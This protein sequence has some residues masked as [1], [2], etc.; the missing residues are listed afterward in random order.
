MP[1][2][3]FSTGFVPKPLTIEREE[4]NEA[5]RQAYGP[6][7]DT[8]DGSALGQFVGI[9]AER[10]ALLWELAEAVNTSQDPDG[11]TGTGLDALCALTG[12]VRRAA[13]ASTVSLTL[14]GTPG[15]LVNSGSQASVVITED[16]FQTVANATIVTLTAWAPTTAYV[17]GDRRTNVGRTYIVAVAGTSAGSGG[18]Q[19]TDSAIVDGTVT[20]RYMGEGTG[21]VDVNAEAVET[22]P[23][24]ATSGSIT[25]IE[26]PVSGWESV[27][28]LLD[29]DVGTDVETD[30]S[31]RARRE[32][33]LEGPGKGTINA[34]R[35]DLLEL[36]DV[37]SVTVFHNPTDVTDGD[38]MPPHSV[39]AVVRG[40]V[41][42]AEDDQAIFDQLL[43]SVAAGIQTHGTAGPGFRSGT[44]TDSQNI[45]HTIEFTR[46]DEIE[47]YVDVTLVK[48]PDTYPADGDAQVEAAIV[49]YG[50]A[51]A[52]GKNAVS[53]SLVAQC[54]TVPGVLE[55]T[56]LFIG[57]APAPVSTAT[58]P[59]SLRELAVYDTS[60]ITV[61]T[62]DGVP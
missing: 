21:A 52:T 55:V 4:I 35:A 58:I 54:F 16:S 13:T 14:T 3:L 47:I 12:T 45:D 41:Q 62:S 10:L 9:I 34:I 5:L 46:P 59:I 33:E 27:I 42:S 51:Q 26:T 11:A 56:S 61:S 53:S 36:E 57:L 39:E 37:I 17:I 8:S 18:P 2:G 49:A 19:T 50:D 48:D 60:R 24:V 6:S 44:A 15:T 7:I 23:T 25:T 38:G 40:T 32:L 22:G 31:L 29:A 43:D 28:N 1:Y 30:E 20:W